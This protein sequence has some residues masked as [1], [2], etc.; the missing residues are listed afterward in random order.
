MATICSKAAE[1]VQRHPKG[2][3]RRLRERAGL[4]LHASIEGRENGAGRGGHLKDTEG[5]GSCGPT[6][7]RAA[8][9]SP[10]VFAYPHP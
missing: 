4:L 3:V 9:Q 6:Q 2:W 10:F 1:A 8:L 5:R 7:S